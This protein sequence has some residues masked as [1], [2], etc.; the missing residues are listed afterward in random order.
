MFVPSGVNREY[1]KALAPPT[2]EELNG[3]ESKKTQVMVVRQQGEAWERPFVSIFEPSTKDQPT[4][5]SVDPLNFNNAIV[6]AIVRSKLADREITDYV[7]CN[8]T[9]TSTINLPEISLSFKGRFAVVRK[10][11][12]SGKLDLTLYIGEGEQL[13]FDRYS[14]KGGTEKK[15]ISVFKDAVSSVDAYAKSTEMAIYPNPSKGDFSIKISEPNWKSLSIFSVDGKKVYT[16]TSGKSIVVISAKEV[17]LQSGIY[18]V[19]LINSQSKKSVQKIV[20]E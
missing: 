3:Y 18:V 17:A 14:L 15:A 16:D 9:D 20:I 4:V 7:I 6:G 10:E 1:T 2:R 11:I 5:Q 8:K 13:G 19:E 12:I